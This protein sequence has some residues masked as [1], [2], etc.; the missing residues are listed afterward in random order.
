M[1]FGLGRSH[2][3]TPIISGLGFRSGPS[4]AHSRALRARPIIVSPAGRA[5]RGLRQFSR[6]IAGVVWPGAGR[7]ATPRGRHRASSASARRPSRARARAR[8]RPRRPTCGRARVPACRTPAR[9]ARSRQRRVSRDRR[10]ARGR[11]RSRGLVGRSRRVAFEPSPPVRLRSGSRSRLRSR[12]TRRPRGSQA[13]TRDTYCFRPRTHRQQTTLPAV[14]RHRFFGYRD[15][16]K[17]T[18][19]ASRP[20]PVATTTNCRPDRAR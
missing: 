10:R 7:G 17:A 14:H 2:I 1:P 4:P 11:T 19:A 12:P 15:R 8:N 13:S 18:S 5:Q 20:A 3:P 9:L 6:G 16:A